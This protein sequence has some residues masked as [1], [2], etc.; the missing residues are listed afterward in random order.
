MYKGGRRHIPWIILL[1]GLVLPSCAYRPEGNGA[2][3]AGM[4]I[5]NPI[6]RKFTWFS[7]LD[8]ADIRTNCAPGA[9]ERFRL[10]YN[11]QYAKHVRAYDVLAGAD[12]SAML[13]ARARGAAGN[14]LELR[15][16]SAEGLFGP[17]NFRRADTALNPAQFAQFRDL[18]RRSGLGSPAPEGLRLHSQDFYWLGA[19]CLEGRFH[20]QAWAAARGDFARIVFLDFLLGHDG[21]GLAYR[22]PHAVGFVEKLPDGGRNRNFEGYFTLTVHADGI[23]RPGI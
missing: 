12:G 3:G 4:G 19:A 23:G 6:E 11:G 17:W 13:T 9:P 22:P 10:V 7:Y 15:F 5:E 16:D 2:S 21:T 8:G 18:L 14:L 1:L 20:Y